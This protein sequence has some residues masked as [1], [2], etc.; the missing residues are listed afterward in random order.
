MKTIL[1]QGYKQEIKLN[2]LQISRYDFEQIPTKKKNPN[3]KVLS[4]RTIYF[5]IIPPEKPTNSRFVPA[6]PNTRKKALLVFSCTDYENLQVN[7]NA[8]DPNNGPPPPDWPQPGDGWWI[9]A[10]S[11]I[12]T[13]PRRRHRR[14]RLQTLQSNLPRNVRHFSPVC[15]VTF[16]T[17][18][19][20][21]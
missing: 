16:G 8:S 4:H 6:K 2:L 5:W 9:A 14:R 18:R 15:G 3:R 21:F 13:D 12:W 11:L 10:G 20:R 17:C 19:Y 7:P 1:N